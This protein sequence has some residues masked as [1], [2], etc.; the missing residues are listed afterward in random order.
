MLKIGTQLQGRYEI[1]E[2]IGQG[3][4]G[5]VYLAVDHK[6]STSNRVAIKETFYETPELADAFEREARLLNSLHHPILPHVSDYFTENGG[7]FLVM[8]YIEGDDLSEILKRDG[9]FPMADVMRWT[10]DILDGLDYLHSQEPPVIHRDIKPNNLKL[11]SRGFIV[12]LDFGLAKENDD[13]TLGERSIFGYS[14]RYSPLEQIEGVGSDA[15]SD[16]FSLGATVYQLLTG[17]PPVDALARASAIVAEKPDPL[18]LASEINNEIPE[19]IAAVINSALALNADQRFASAK[20]M[21]TALHYATDPEAGAA[22]KEDA[23]L[24]ANEAPVPPVEVAAFPALQAF[25]AG[26]EHDTT[27]MVHQEPTPYIEQEVAETGSTVEPHDFE[28]AADLPIEDGSVHELGPVD[29]AP[30]HVFAE[31][32]ETPFAE[33]PAVEDVAISIDDEAAVNTVADHP[34]KIEYANAGTNWQ[35]GSIWLAL[36]AASVF[37]LVYGISRFGSADSVAVRETDAAVVSEQQ[38]QTEVIEAPAV[39]PAKDEAPA[40]QKAA[41]AKSTAKPRPVASDDA[42]IAEIDQ[43]VSP[44][45]VQ[46]SPVADTPEPARQNVRN[47]GPVRKQ[48]PARQSPQYNEQRTPASSIED[49]F[50]GMTPD[51]VRREARRRW[52]LQNDQNDEELRRERRRQRRLQRQENWPF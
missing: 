19:S 2:Q 1:E 40:E 15:R 37:A 25:K 23:V 13:A 18:V 44:A 7:S 3:G 46:N 35:K 6:F 42:A 14:R 8:E 52:Q 31:A 20:A 29:E 24:D 34:G 51:E 11:T 5:A 38:P 45:R 26:I 48:N 36:I 41:A 22:A 33:Y 28:P 49:V 32:D 17:R 4:M 39:E 21:S 12:L 9:T 47:S 43:P 27:E 10:H 16:I 30:V 50:T